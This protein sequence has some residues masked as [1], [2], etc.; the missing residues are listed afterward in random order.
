MSRS[1]TAQG[2]GITAALDNLAEKLRRHPTAQGGKGRRSLE[3]QPWFLVLG[4]TGAGKSSLIRR[5]ALHL[6]P[7]GPEEDDDCCRLWLTDQ[8]VILEL[9]VDTCLHPERP[10]SWSALLQWL[11]R[12]R[13]RAGLNGI[14]VVLDVRTLQEHDKDTLTPWSHQLRRYLDNLHQ[15]LGLS[16]PIHLVLNHADRLPGFD[17]YF[18]APS[19][20]DRQPF[21]GIRLGMTGS[22][23]ASCLEGLETLRQRLEGQRLRRL[24][25]CTNSVDRAGVMLFP[26][27]LS[28]LTPALDGFLQVLLKHH[29]GHEPPHLAGLGLTSATKEPYFAQ[30]LWNELIMPCRYRVMPTRRRR[31]TRRLS[32]AVVTSLALLSLGL[33]G[34]ALS[35]AHQDQ[36]RLL[37][38]GESALQALG[39]LAEDTA[40]DTQVVGEALLRLQAAQQYLLAADT[41]GQ[42][43]YLPARPRL[44]QQAEL[45]G[46]A[47]VITMD[48]RFIPAVLATLTQ[49]LESLEAQWEDATRSADPELRKAHYDHLRLYLMLTDRR[50]LDPPVAAPPLRDYWRALGYP[51]V[52]GPVWPTDL[53]LEGRGGQGLGL[54]AQDEV[55]VARARTRL[56]SGSDLDSLYA[57]LQALAGPDQGTVDLARV[58][59]REH[60]RRLKV[61][62]PLPL[63]HTAEMRWSLIHSDIPELV[64]LATMGDWVIH[65]PEDAPDEHIAE[66]QE[67]LIQALRSRYTED[68][69]DHWQRFLKGLELQP[70][71]HLQTLADTLHTLAADT[72]GILPRL[73]AWLQ[74]EQF[75]G[76]A[77]ARQTVPLEQVAHQVARS[78]RIDH[79]LLKPPGAGSA[80][81]GADPLSPC[82]E[83]LAALQAEI[84][85]MAAAPD[86]AGQARLHA[87]ALLSG[88]G[89]GTA[90]QRA[91]VAIPRLTD[92]KD[93]GC[94]PLA[95]L[96]KSIVQE[97][98]RTVIRQATV[99]LEKTW[100]SQV[101]DGY[102]DRLAGRFPFHPQG[103]DA[104]LVDLV[105]LIH[106]ERGRLWRFT[107]E[108]LDPFLTERQGR[109]QSRQWIGIG[110][111]FSRAFL[112]DLERAGRLTSALFADG[113]DEPRLGFHLYPIPHPGLSEMRFETNGQQ[114]RY[115]NEPQEWRQFVWPGDIRSPGARVMAVDHGGRPLGEFREEGVWALFRLLHTAH[116][117][118]EHSDS[119]LYTVRW[120]LMGE[121]DAPLELRFHL[122]AD[123][124]QNFIH[125]TLF[126][127]FRLSRSPFP[128][129]SP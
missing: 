34:L 15:T 81:E 45:L 10:Q 4:A 52:P 16:C 89:S 117:D 86:P 11:G 101:H 97:S 8:G 49:Q 62:H 94:R 70:H 54:Q 17:D 28:R 2:A 119:H 113:R 63:R 83:L 125:E 108:H 88:Q 128:R 73:S 75:P 65:G 3:T 33:A 58:L 76:E 78:G 27:Q 115:R 29:S 14:V 127:D 116:M 61:S 13:P 106:P 93:S 53:W 68:H 26:Y 43:Q 41:A 60:A 59:G 55:L 47:L 18:R 37:A 57:R 87:A 82:L 124:R 92:S 126:Q 5:S 35:D 23:R 96:M 95:P 74:A 36:T 84:Q 66:Q 105:G 50:H 44:R 90:L 31:M 85:G 121:G 123:R 22:A 38:Q 91:W 77:N 9:D 32:L 103:E 64:S 120:P 99:D 48:R 80:T 118:R 1:P 51:P 102:Q 114:Y 79:D 110:P 67:A 112:H 40:P 129:R 42:W 30:G 6:E 21:L 39:A 107:Q 98:W 19:S 24:R 20:E 111:G 46:N 12:H 69:E 122:R 104:A 25:Q 71:T 56:Q 100:Q 109:W 72:N 7:L